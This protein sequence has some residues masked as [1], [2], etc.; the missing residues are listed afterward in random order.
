MWKISD[1][2]DKIIL[3]YDFLKAGFQHR[4]FNLSS[5]ANTLKPLLE[6]R[7]KKELTQSSLLMS[8]SRYQREKFPHPTK[9]PLDLRAKAPGEFKVIPNLFISTFIKNN[10]TQRDLAIWLKHI[11][12]HKGRLFLTEE[13]TLLT[14]VTNV[15]FLEEMSNQIKTKPKSIHTNL[16]GILIDSPQSFKARTELLHSLLWN[17]ALQKGELVHLHVSSKKIL[18]LVPQKQA[19]FLVQ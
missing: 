9:N 5:L 14:I 10:L 13:D 1:E 16:T 6:R 11:Q 18:A 2:L 3:H 7:L 17:L 19:H 8:L 4:L 15:S 12:D